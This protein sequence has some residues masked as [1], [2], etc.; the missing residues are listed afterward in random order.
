M[1]G[2]GIGALILYLLFVLS[3]VSRGPISEEGPGPPPQDRDGTCP[4]SH[5]SA[6][7]G[8][9]RL[10]SPGPEAGPA[11]CSLVVELGLQD[12][13]HLIPVH[14]HVDAFASLEELGSLS[15]FGLHL[16][17]GTG[18]PGTSLIGGPIAETRGMF[19]SQTTQGRALALPV[20]SSVALGNLINHFFFVFFIQ[21][22]RITAV[23]TS[24]GYWK[25]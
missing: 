21:K 10:R 16:C 25:E 8:F 17:G 11:C 4:Q 14:T 20:L 5:A 1:P 13:T 24:Q 12:V 3:V 6:P 22:I 2:R 19:L 9:P 7:A 15:S 23:S 18:A